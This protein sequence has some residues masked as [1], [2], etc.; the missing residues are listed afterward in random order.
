MM[1][2]LYFWADMTRKVR[3]VLIA[4]VALILL[5]TASRT[6]LT[7]SAICV[8]GYF[9]FP[10]VPKLFSL[11]TM[12]LILLAGTMVYVLQPD[13]TGDNLSGRIVLTMRPHNRDGSLWV[14]RL[15]RRQGSLVCR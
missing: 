9:L 14:S 13:A 4:C 11:F 1:Y 6:M 12:P 5:T 3:I 2:M 15:L 8:V 10:L 7:F